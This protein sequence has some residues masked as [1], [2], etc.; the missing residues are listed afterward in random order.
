MLCFISSWN[1]LN[2][3]ESL[4]KLPFKSQHFIS[5]HFVTLAALV[6]LGK[7]PQTV[8]GISILDTNQAIYSGLG[9][10]GSSSTGQAQYLKS[11]CMAKMQYSTT[12]CWQWRKWVLLADHKLLMLMGY[13]AFNVTLAEGEKGS[14]S[15]WSC[16]TIPTTQAKTYKLTIAKLCMP[17]HLCTTVLIYPWGSNSCKWV[18]LESKQKVGATITF[19]Y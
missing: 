11:T 2:D 18:T 9:V 1:T 16:N 5:M 8:P 13:V 17:S 12:H 6:I 7:E 3:P 14:V 15:T 19:V 10:T 4:W